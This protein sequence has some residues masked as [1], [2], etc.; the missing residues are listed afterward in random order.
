MKFYILLSSLIIEPRHSELVSLINY[1]GLGHRGD[2][3]PGYLD[4]G[5][6]VSEKDNEVHDDDIIAKTH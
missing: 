1:E 2:T 6:K 3:G 5:S 4:S